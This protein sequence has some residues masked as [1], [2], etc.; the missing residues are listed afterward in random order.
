MTRSD[1]QP[2]ITETSIMNGKKG[3]YTFHCLVSENKNSLKEQIEKIF[4]VNV[5]KI[6]TLIVK[7]KL[8]KSLKTRKAS[9]GSDWKKVFVKLEKD[10]KIDIFDQV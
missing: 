9:K 5:S 3:W 2:V 4:K 10:Q 8:K 7:G 1:L 6:K